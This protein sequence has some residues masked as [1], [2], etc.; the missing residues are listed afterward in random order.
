MARSLF[1]GGVGDQVFGEILVGTRTVYGEVTDS[2]GDPAAVTLTVWSAKTAGTQLTDLLDAAG[3]ATTTV[4]TTV[5]TGEIPQFQGP[6]AV[7]TVWV[8][9]D[10]G[11]TR[12]R[13]FA[14]AGGGGGAVDSVNGETGTVVL[15]AAEIG[16]TPAGGISAT[17]VQAAITELDSEKQPLDSDLTTIAGLTATTNNFLV[18]VSS[19]WASRTPAQAKT[20]LA[21]VAAD[22]SD[23]S[24]AADARVAAAA[25]TGTGN[26][27]RATSPTLVTP[28][29]GTPSALVLT[30]ATGLPQ[31]GVTS[32]TTDLALKAALASPTFSGTP[33]LPNAIIDEEVVAASG[34]SGTVTLDLATS[35]IFT[36]SPSGNVTTL[37][38][39]N[40]PASGRAV[41]VTLLVTQGGT[42]RTI[43]T[44]TGGIFMAAATPTQVA[45]K[46]CAFTYVTVDGGTVWY[47]SAAVQV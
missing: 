29:L 2:N 1:G 43:A 9:P 34:T 14:S 41:T 25:A 8:S 17:N 42:P 45:S 47:C 31:S 35:R 20:T 46:A 13:L 5:G 40:V 38:I 27:V 36:L 26:L 33:V 4:T 37:T 16:S 7:T 21:I 39:S 32:L 12:Y 23:F 11:T 44:P 18:A 24:T 30:N 6:D 15:N 19:A 3:G 28:A 10:S 22:V